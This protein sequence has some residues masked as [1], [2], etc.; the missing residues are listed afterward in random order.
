MDKQ[1]IKEDLDQ[2]FGDEILEN[3]QHYMDLCKRK[4]QGM[5]E[6]LMK[7]RQAVAK[8]FAAGS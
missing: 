1:K 4:Y 5:P 7:C 6:Q 3:R 2:I 8:R